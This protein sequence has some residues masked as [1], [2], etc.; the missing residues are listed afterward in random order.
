M[1]ARKLARPQ[2]LVSLTLAA[3]LAVLVLLP[4]PVADGAF[5]ATIACEPTGGGAFCDAYPSSSG[6][7][8]HWSRSGSVYFVRLC[9]GSF[10]EVKCGL[11]RTGGTVTVTITAPDGSSDTDSDYVACSGGGGANA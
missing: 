6:Y 5:T 9:P 3:A 11:D 7:T 2:V 8:Y 4:A 1:Q 10:C